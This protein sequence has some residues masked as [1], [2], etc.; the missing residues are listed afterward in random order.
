MTIS[1]FW[2]YAMESSLDKNGN[3]FLRDFPVKVAGQFVNELQDILSYIFDFRNRDI[4]LPK[5]RFACC[6]TKYIYYLFVS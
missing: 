6:L 5:L 1:V 3:C 4:L 2:M